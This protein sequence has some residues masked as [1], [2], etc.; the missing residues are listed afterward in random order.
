MLQGLIKRFGVQVTLLKPPLQKENRL[1]RLY[2]TE[3]F[4]IQLKNKYREKDFKVIINT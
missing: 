4:Q 3:K 2:W 1:H